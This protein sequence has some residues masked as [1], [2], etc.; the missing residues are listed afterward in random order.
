M[1]RECSKQVNLFQSS[2]LVL[3]PFPVLWYID[4]AHL[5]RFI[6]SPGTL[7]PLMKRILFD[8]EWLSFSPPESL[9]ALTNGFRKFNTQEIEMLFHVNLRN[10]NF[11]NTAG[12]NF[13]SLSSFV[14]WKFTGTRGYGLRYFRAHSREVV[15]VVQLID[16]ERTWPEWWSRSRCH[17]Q[18]SQGYV[19]AENTETVITLVRRKI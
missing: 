19:G 14:T 15:W 7:S 10:S 5:W 13:D 2:L 11:R 17:E 4:C 6:A 16:G 9:D 1:C 3:T 18:L 8:L 12:R